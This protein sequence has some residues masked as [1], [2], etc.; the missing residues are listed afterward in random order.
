MVPEEVSF[1]DKNGMW[2]TRRQLPLTLGYAITVHRTQCMICSKLVID[3][4]GVNWKPGMFYTILSRTRRLSDIIILDYDRKSFKVVCHILRLFSC[5]NSISSFRYRKMHCMKCLDLNN[6]RK[7]IQFEL[8]N[9][10]V[11]K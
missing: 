1:K 3:L 6:S 2:M 11:L 7:T 10:W 9:T 8:S 5:L 4:T